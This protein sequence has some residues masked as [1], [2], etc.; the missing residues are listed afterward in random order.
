M[1][2]PLKHGLTVL[3]GGRKRKLYRLK[4]GGV[5][6]VRFQCRG[7]DIERSTG[8]NLEAAAKDKAKR[9]VDAEINGDVDKSRELKMRSDAPLLRKICDRYL[10][11]YGSNKTSRGNV[12]GLAKMLRLGSPG[13]TLDNSTASALTAK[14]VRDYE[15]AEEKR[16]LR[17]RNGAMDRASELHV[18]N[19]VWSLV[20]QARSIFSPKF[21]HWYEDFSLPNLDQFRKQGVLAP[22]RRGDP[23]ALDEG[24]IAAMFAASKQ[25]A[26]E[27]P[28]CYVAFILFSLLGMRNSEIRHARKCWLRRNGAGWMLDIIDRPEE[29]FFCKGNPRQLPVGQ[30]IVDLLDQYYKASPDGDFL[31]PA[32]HK[33]DRERIV[34]RRHAAWSGNWIK[35]YTKVSYELRRYAGSLVLKKTGSYA[36]TKKFLGHANVATTERWYAYMLGDLPTL[37]FSDFVNGHSLKEQQ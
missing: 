18:R 5:F 32:A 7:K 22:K 15:A 29:D 34:D 26:I 11:K 8:L 37:S 14:L 24:A 12:S 16:I 20:R 27:D 6:Y 28:S 33:T 31:V 35:D 1:I 4:P 19:S 17:D 23:R 25:L 21:M 2:K 30:E 3:A 10:E 9:I 36:A 13:C